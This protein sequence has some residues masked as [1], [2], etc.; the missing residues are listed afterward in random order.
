MTMNPAKI[1]LLDLNPTA[2]SSVALRAVLESCSGPDGIT[3]RRKVVTDNSAAL[4]SGELLEMISSFQPDVIF[5]TTS[6]SVSEQ[7]RT[8]F[9][10][11]RREGPT[12]QVIVVT[13]AGEVRE[14]FDCV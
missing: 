1:L 6:G 10:S 7:A 8:L 4:Y 3:L 13:Q 12:I 11:M 2:N 5:L 14:M 9:P